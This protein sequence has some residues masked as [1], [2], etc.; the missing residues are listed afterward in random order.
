MRSEHWQSLG[1]DSKYAVIGVDQG[2]GLLVY[3]GKLLAEAHLLNP[4]SQYREWTLCSR[5]I[6]Q[7]AWGAMPDLDNI[8]TYLKEF[9]DGFCAREAQRSLAT[10]YSDL[11]QVLVE[12]QDQKY[13]KDYKYEC[14]APY[15]NKQSYKQQAQHART[16]AIA[17]YK[18]ALASKNLRRTAYWSDENLREELNG[19]INGEGPNGW[20]WCAD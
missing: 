1:W 16:L 2:D 13:E 10:F 14:F 18:Q 20:F 19:L 3:S 7:D 15:I 8:N 11:Y 9:P 6:D 5:I 12:L 17:H 4:N